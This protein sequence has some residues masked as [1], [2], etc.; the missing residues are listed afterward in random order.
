MKCANVLLLALLLTTAVL[1]DKGQSM[2]PD[3]KLALAT[4]PPNMGRDNCPVGLQVKHG[5]GLATSRSADGP[6]INGKP[7]S[8]ELRSPSRIRPFNSP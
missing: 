1:S 6:S 3:A 4:P 2:S 5:P 7:F 8:G